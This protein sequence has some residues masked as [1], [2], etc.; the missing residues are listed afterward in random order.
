MGGGT[1]A[2]AAIKHKCNYIGF[3][4]AENYCKLAEKN[5][6]NYKEKGEV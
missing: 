3:E 6:T 4:K 5:I 2:I 1:T